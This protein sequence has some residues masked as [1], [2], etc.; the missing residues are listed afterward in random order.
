MERRVIA[1]GLYR[2]Y[3][4]KW[5]FVIGSSVHSETGEAFVTYFPL[6][7]EKVE[8]FIRPQDMFLEQLPSGTSDLQPWRFQESDSLDL[9]VKEK[10][11][12]LKRADHLLKS[13]GLA[14]LPE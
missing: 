13:L 11:Q 6:Y 8:L 2:H 12:L 7:L 3:K 10:V 14:I 4:D 1:G 5:Y 9:S